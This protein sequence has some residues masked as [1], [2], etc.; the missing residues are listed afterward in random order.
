MYISEVNHGVTFTLWEYHDSLGNI[1]HAGV[2]RRNIMG[3][4]IEYML[5]IYPLPPGYFV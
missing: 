4:D 1:L 5:L 3:I 2:N